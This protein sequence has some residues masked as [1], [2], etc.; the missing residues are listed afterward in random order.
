MS[1]DNFIVTKINYF[2]K[3]DENTGIGLI[4]D[5]I[6]CTKQINRRIHRFRYPILI[7]NGAKDVIVNSTEV[8]ETYQRIRSQQKTFYLIENGY[9]ELYSDKEKYIVR[10]SILNWVFARVKESPILGE[11][12]FVKLRT[13]ETSKKKNWISFRIG[14]YCLCYLFG[15]KT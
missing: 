9:H 15:I 10:K 7:I 14:F 1:K 3:N 5:F 6:H 11:I 4:R 13:E 2:F 8:K 12:K